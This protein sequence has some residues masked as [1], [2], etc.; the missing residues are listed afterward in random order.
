MNALEIKDLSK[1]FGSFSLQNLTLTVPMGTALGLIGE[2]GAGKSTTI[3]LILGQLRRD[4]GEIRILGQDTDGDSVSVREDIGVVF[5]E[6]CFPDGLNA[7]QVDKVERCIY[8]NWDSGASR[9]NARRDHSGHHEKGAGV[10][11]IRGL[12]LKDIFELWAQCRV[13]LVLTGVYL[14]L[15]LFTSVGMM[16]LA[17]MPIYA[18]G[19]DE[20]CRWERYALAMPVRKSDLFWSRFLLGVIAIALGAAVQTLA[21]LLSGRGE[22]LSSLAVAAPS[23]VVYLLIT[24]PLMMK[25]GVEKGRFLLLLLTMAFML[26]S[27]AA[28]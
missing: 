14:L 19:Y 6:I 18:L 15:P 20:R 11:K 21:A 5:D 10:M 8:K 9:S 2:N 3:S 25:L 1:S 27:G 24:L 4:S 26:L 16:L 23:A 28:A 22:L 13:Q 17:M 12:L 7:R